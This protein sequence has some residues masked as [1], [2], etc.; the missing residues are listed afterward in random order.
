MLEQIHDSFGV[1]MCWK[2]FAATGVACTTR[3]TAAISCKCCTIQEQLTLCHTFQTLALAAVTMADTLA[4]DG[5]LASQQALHGL[6]CSLL[7]PQIGA[8]TC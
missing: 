6:S 8:A 5:V 2:T 3:S 7:H 4:V 1:H